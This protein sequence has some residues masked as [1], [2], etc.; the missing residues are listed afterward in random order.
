MLPLA[1][2]RISEIIVYERIFLSL[3]EWLGVYHDSNAT[4]IAVDDTHPRSF[5]GHLISCVSCTS[6]WVSFCL[7]GVKTF[8]P[9]LGN[10]LIKVFAY[11]KIAMVLSQKL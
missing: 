10:F 9:K 11:N 8:K 5:F 2:I 6:V 4:P 1:I 3:R 7:L